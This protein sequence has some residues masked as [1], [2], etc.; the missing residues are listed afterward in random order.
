MFNK[1]FFK[2]QFVSISIFYL[3]NLA[4]STSPKG[5]SELERAS[6]ATLIG[7]TH[8]DIHRTRGHSNLLKFEY[9]YLFVINGL[10]TVHGNSH[11]TVFF[12]FLL[13]TRQR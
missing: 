3:K 1:L 8:R 2:F 12:H 7:I 6:S 9:Y 11:V 13:L 4:T 10:A 5:S